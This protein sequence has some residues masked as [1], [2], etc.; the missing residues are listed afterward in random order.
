MNDNEKGMSSPKLGVIQ[1]LA[2]LTMSMMKSRANP[3][4]FDAS[5]FYSSTELYPFFDLFAEPD[6]KA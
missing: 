1:E 4:P 5:N 2:S 3:T 6:R